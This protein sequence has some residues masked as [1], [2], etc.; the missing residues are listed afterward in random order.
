LGDAFFDE[1]LSE[2]RA[3]DFYFIR[4]L[5]DHLQ[6]VF[7]CKPE[8]ERT[9]SK[10]IADVRDDGTLECGERFTVNMVALRFTAVQ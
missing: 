7:Y 6:S 4:R 3:D 8:A 5:Q 10:G 2:I 1:E 9:H